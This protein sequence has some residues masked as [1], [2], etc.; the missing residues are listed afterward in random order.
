MS[1]AT[2]PKMTL[3]NLDA[4]MNQ[5]EHPDPELE[6]NRAAC[7]LRITELLAARVR[8]GVIIDD[9]LREDNFPKVLKRTTGYLIARG[10]IRPEHAKEGEGLVSELIKKLVT[11]K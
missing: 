10:F 9:E 8:A 11:K 5:L 7:A 4:I 3:A 6:E 2:T 1:V